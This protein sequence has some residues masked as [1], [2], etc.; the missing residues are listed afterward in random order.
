MYPFPR[1]DLPQVPGDLGLAPAVPAGQPGSELAAAGAW[2]Q[3]LS[4]VAGWVLRV[5]GPG[6]KTALYGPGAQAGQ[7]EAWMHQL[8]AWS[9]WP[10]AQ[11]RGAWGCL[12][13]T[14]EG[15]FTALAFRHLSPQVQIHA[16]VR[17]AEE[18]AAGH[19]IAP[20]VW[21]DATDSGLPDAVR[22][23][24]EQFWVREGHRVLA[25]WASS[26]LGELTREAYRGRVLARGNFP[27]ADLAE[28]LGV[29]VATISG[30]TTGRSWDP[31]INRARGVLANRRRH[32]W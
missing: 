31:P 6:G 16:D 4:S 8:A 24:E 22:R 3:V 20:A 18:H 1:P 11:V 19:L 9:L 27:S 30:A 28:R 32:T 13:R 15:W 25:T 29:S 21:S 14:D 5:A 7:V 2:Y 17:A 10:T 23:V 26:S 12:A